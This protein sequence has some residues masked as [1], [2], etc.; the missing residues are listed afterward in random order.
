M[1]PTL[2]GPLRRAKSGAIAHD[3]YERP[4]RAELLNTLDPAVVRRE[5][6]YEAILL[7]WERPG[8]ACHRRIVARWTQ[9]ELGIE[10]EEAWQVGFRPPDAARAMP[11]LPR[12]LHTRDSN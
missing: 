8:A 5:L 9:E 11:S 7:C 1:R 10:M 2:V 12:E 4:Y 3:E 6:G